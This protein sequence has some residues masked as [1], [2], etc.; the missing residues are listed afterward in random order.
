[1]KIRICLSLF[2][3][4]F[5]LHAAHNK[6]VIEESSAN[7]DLMRE[8][9]VLDR[10]LLI[11]GEIASRIENYQDFPIETLSEA[12]KLIRNFIENYHEKLEEEYIFPHFEKVGKF[13][14]LI[15]TLQDQHQAGRHLTDYILAHAKESELHDDIQRL[16]LADYIKLFIRMYHPH[17]AREDT[18]VF[19]E[20]KNLV[21]QKEYK[22]LGELFEEKEHQL[23]GD[24]GYQKIVSD[25]ARLEKILGIYK[26]SQFTPKISA[27]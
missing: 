8:H 9:G 24:N 3:S 27:S 14:D 12:A 6:E 11:Y 13:N 26:L 21:S 22:E 23:F 4:P 5:L 25:V 7:E 1:M 2:L 19:P 10:L 18:V 17:E 15:H 20:F 16:I